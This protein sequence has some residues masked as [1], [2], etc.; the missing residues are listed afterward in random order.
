MKKIL[1]FAGSNSSNSINA[2]LLQYV[3]QKITTHQVTTINLT[4]YESPIYSADFEKE[5]GIPV[6]SAM[7]EKMIDSYDALIISVNEHNSAPSAFFKNHMDWLSRINNQ[8]LLGKKVFLMSTSPGKRGAK[9]ALEF[10]RDILFPRFGAEIIESF[11]LPSFHEN[12]DEVSQQLTN[13]VYTLGLD[14]L[15]TNFEQNLLD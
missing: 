3:V 12:F 7:L 8:F 5:K 1:A 4:D 10:T 2:K 6:P 15:I 13:E 14:D 11:S 9:T